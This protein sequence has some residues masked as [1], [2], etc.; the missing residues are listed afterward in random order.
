[1]IYTLNN[2]L[3]DVHINSFGA[4]LD[5]VIYIP[6]YEQLLWQGDSNFWD[7]KDITIFPMVGRL[8][9]G[10]Y[11]YQGKK[12]TMDIHGIACYSEFSVIEKTDLSITL[13]LKSSR[14]TLEKYPFKF[15]LFV[16]YTL[17][18]NKLVTS[19]KV[20]NLSDKVM[21]F[22]IGGHPAYIIDGN[23]DKNGQL[24]TANN[25]IIFDKKQQ[26]N[27]IVMD[28]SNVFVS[29]VEKTESI[30]KIVLDK[31]VFDKDAIIFEDFIGDITLVRE[32]GRKISF[33]LNSP[34]ILAM[35]SHKTMG[36]YVAIEPWWGLPDS[37]PPKRE[38]DQKL[39]MNTLDKG[40]VFRYT[41]T[42]EYN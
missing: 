12:F 42:T 18:N 15:E 19:Y 32:N 25:Y 30:D 38:L 1:M 23:I 28:E 27:K 9:D 31:K 16:N 2:E 8:K 37:N 11:T 6:T 29:G 14:S 7:G 26:L 35:W 36:N 20:N 40:E 41:F 3:L 22:G 39:K 4:C 34:P 21:T 24:N 10:Y 33:E 17:D 5:K 13:L